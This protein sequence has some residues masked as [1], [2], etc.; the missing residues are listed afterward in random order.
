M[1]LLLAKYWDK[2]VLVLLV[3]AALA[4]V[5]GR[6]RSD[7]NAYWKPKYDLLQT[8][9]AAE[10]ES[11]AQAIEA[12]RVR[13]ERD[14]ELA[15]L[16]SKETSDHL[17]SRLAFHTSNADSLLK[18]LRNAEA[19]RL[20]PLAPTASAPAE[21][22]NYEADPTRLSEPAR[23]FLVGEAAAAEEQGELLLACRKDYQTVKLAC[24]V[25]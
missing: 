5:Y 25:Q 14:L 15:Q 19:N 6:G 23:G 17:Q 13:R 3:I 21:C 1:W 8:T 12:E 24:G 11:H 2:I 16:R 20:R 9:I 10:R 22:G 4:W 18:R 7:A